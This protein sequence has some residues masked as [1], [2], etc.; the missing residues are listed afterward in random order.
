MATIALFLWRLK[1]MFKINNFES[2]YKS[3]VE[4]N[5]EVENLFTNIRVEK[6]CTNIPYDSLKELT[7]SLP[8]YDGK[9]YYVT[10]CEEFSKLLNLYNI[11]GNHNFNDIYISVARLENYYTV[12]L[13]YQQILGSCVLF[14]LTEKQFQKLLSIVNS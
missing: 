3:F 11:Y 8:D 9:S 4:F 10:P 5:G 12:S 6:H 14:D 1:D 2:K 13:K 7:L